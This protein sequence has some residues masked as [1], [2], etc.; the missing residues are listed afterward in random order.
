[1]KN[2]L[3]TVLDLGSTKVAGLVASLGEHDDL[4][5]HAVAL[6]GCKGV[7]RGVVTDLEET[8]ASIERVLRKLKEGCGHET[9]GVVVGVSGNHIEGVSAQ[10]YVPIYPRSRSI[11][12]DDVLQVIK[13]SRQLSLPP[14]REQIQA[15]PREFRVDGQRGVQ[16]PVGM[17]GSRLETVTYIVTGQTTH[18]QNI[19]KA[20]NMAG[21]RVDS[22]V[23]ESLASGLAVL[24]SD[25]MDLGAAVIDIGGGSTDMAIFVN[26]AIT[27]SCVIPVG[28][29]LVTSDVSK[30]LK[31]APEEAERLKLVYGSAI[32]NDVESGQKV[33]V[34]QIGQ[35]HPRPLQRKVLCEIIES[36]MREIAV[37]VRRQLEESSLVDSIPG[38]VVLTGGGAMLGGAETLFQEVL[39]HTRVRTAEPDIPEMAFSSHSFATSVGLARFAIEC[40]EGDLVAAGGNSDWKDH[41]RTLWFKKKK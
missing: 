14:D 24:T 10:G 37:M 34:T 39:K 33:E 12:R 17:V 25:E 28:G 32:P 30:L 26:G 21:K 13:H 2:D 3:V 31:T 5:I 1:M 29:A 19:E 11:T 15:I 6:E 8:S 41:I 38:G 22:M 35:E 36:R 9:G 7:R 27:Y 23:L 40:S 18:I 16:R 4:R 20:V